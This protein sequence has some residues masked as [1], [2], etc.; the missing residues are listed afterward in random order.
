MTLG[1][2]VRDWMTPAPITLGLDGSLADAWALM[3][4]N[5]IHHLPIVEEGRA[6]GVVAEQDL[7][8]FAAARGRLSL[9]SMPVCWVML[10]CDF[11]VPP[12]TPVA[13]VAEKMESRRH[14]VMVVADDGGVA[15]VFTITDALR[16]LRQHMAAERT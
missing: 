6:V 7:R 4:I 5:R 14:T 13:D 9:K 12:D 11:S 3:S 10:S 1:S 2:R 16:A 8:L 15:G